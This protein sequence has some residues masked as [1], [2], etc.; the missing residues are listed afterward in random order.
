MHEDLLGYLLGALEPHEMRRIEGLLAADP[1][2][3]AQL[4]ELERALGPLDEGASAM[5][6]PTPC[7]LVART[8]ASLPEHSWSADGDPEG[9]AESTFQ[10]FPFA[11]LPVMQDRP[12]RGG[13]H[14]GHWADWVGGSAAVLILLGLLIPA[15]AEGRLE[16][17]KA[18]CQDRLRQLGTALTQFVHR[19]AQSRLPAVAESG[20]EAFAGVYSIRLHDAGLLP[21]PAVRWCP[22]LPMPP[23]RR[24]SF[25]SHEAVDSLADLHGAPPDLLREM[26]RYAGG[27]YAYTLGVI[28]R[29]DLKPPRFESRSTF[30]VMSDAPPAGFHSRSDLRR[31]RSHGGQ[32]INVLFEDGRVQFVTLSA[33]DDLPDHPLL[34]HRGLRE[35]G[36]NPDDASLAPSWSAPFIDAIQR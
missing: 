33:I 3:R 26:Q 1:E 18:A 21:D 28:D 32:G 31:V 15:L 13:S 35:A 16:A 23:Q 12:E 17:R 4:A 8:M 19:N 36:V 6:E 25:T 22:S 2:L 7:D 14:G 30:A 11:A 34:N 10:P 20:P 9:V 5:A 24:F 29:H 27:H